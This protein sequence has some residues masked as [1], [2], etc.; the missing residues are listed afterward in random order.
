MQ[1]DIFNEPVSVY[2]PIT[3]I[4]H[5]ATRPLSAFLGAGH[6]F[7][8]QFDALRNA[9]NAA[10]FAQSIGDADGCHRHLD[11]YTRMKQGLYAAM[12]GGVCPVRKTGAPMERY[13]NVLCLDIDAPKPGKEPNG[14]EWVTDWREVKHTISALPWVAYCGLSASA[15]G[16]F[17]LIPIADH[18][19]HAAHWRA[20]RM[21]L[22]KHLNL[23][24]DEATKDVRRLRFMSYDQMPHIN[25]AAEVFTATEDEPRHAPRPVA[26]RWNQA[27]DD[28]KRIA[29]CVQQINTHGIDITEPYE[30]WLKAAAAFAHHMGEG[31]RSLFHVIASQ[32]AKY[33]ER[34]NNRLYTSMMSAAPTQCDIATF[35]YLCKSHGIEVKPERSPRNAALPRPKYTP[36]PR[37]EVPRPVA[38]LK[39]IADKKPW[40]YDDFM[41]PLGL[42]PI[43]LGG[44]SESEFDAMMMQHD[45]APY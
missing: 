17:A 11:A 13:S 39:R 24:V 7:A 25:H 23:S 12:I 8:S 29:E 14:N 19:T 4:N 31:G 21:L 35:F 36:R 16:V 32:N 2:Y 40:L 45:A 5:V 34:E 37:R 33:N 18:A 1:R 6:L 41:K 28:A 26:V 38:V 9:Y 10:I 43:D 42:Y 30:M 22:K 15:H 44:I 3:N 27:G 20:L